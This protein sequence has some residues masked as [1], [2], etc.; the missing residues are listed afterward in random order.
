[1][2]IALLTLAAMAAFGAPARAE[3]VAA[4]TPSIGQ[5]LQERLDED[6]GPR[7]GAYLQALT[8]RFVEEALT[9]AGA[10][11][12]EGQ[13]PLTVDITILDAVPNR[14]TLQQ[15]SDHPGLSLE[16]FGVGGARF[17]A[18]IRD[19]NGLVVATVEHD[20]YQSNIFDAISASTWTDARHAARG[21]ARKV[22]RAYVALG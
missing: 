9:R 20:Y 3:T 5:A 2:R 14:P 15:M 18:V 16:S 22:A 13:A 17:Q 21:F 12:S 10:T 11:L 8:E 4:P 1:M 7:E 19:V 6:Y